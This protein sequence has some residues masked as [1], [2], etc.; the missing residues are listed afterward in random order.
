[1]AQRTG[2]RLTILLPDDDDQKAHQYVRSQAA[3]SLRRRKLVIRYR[4]LLD[5]GLATIQQA[6]NSEASGVAILSECTLPSE[7]MQ[8]LIED[9]EHPVMLI[10]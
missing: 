4:R 1:M 10:R 3:E 5:T 2:G 6:I 8:T 9:L 7:D